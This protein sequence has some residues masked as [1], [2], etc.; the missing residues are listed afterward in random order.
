MV[1]GESHRKHVVNKCKRR[2]VLGNTVIEEVDH[3]MHVGIELCSYSSSKQR[4]SNMCNRG[5][6]VLA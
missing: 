2:F 3:Y 6:K 5:N 1:F 4:T